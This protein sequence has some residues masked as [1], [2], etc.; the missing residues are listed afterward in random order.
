MERKTELLSVLMPS[1]DRRGVSLPFYTE[2]VPGYLTSFGRHKK[3][4]CFFYLFFFGSGLIVVKDL[5]TC[6]SKVVGPKLDLT[7]SLNQ[8]QMYHGFK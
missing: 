6:I 1:K 2:V 3:K 7:R 8:L 5:R 4:E